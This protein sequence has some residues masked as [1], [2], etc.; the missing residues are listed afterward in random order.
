MRIDFHSAKDAINQHRHG[1]SLAL[2]KR[3]DWISGQPTPA[4]TIAGELRWKQL[5]RLD[6]IVYAAV[7]TRR[8]DVLWIISVRRASRKERRRYEG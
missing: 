5:E 1:V 8:G 3:F 7:F 6:G 4:R 2:A